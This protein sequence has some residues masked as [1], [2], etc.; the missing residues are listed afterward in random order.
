MTPDG[1]SLFYDSDRN[2]NADIWRTTVGVNQPDAITHDPADEFGPALS[3]DGKWLAYYSYRAG[4]THGIVI[5]KPMDGGPIVEV[6]DDSTV[7]IWPAWSADGRA[8]FWQCSN[9]QTRLCGGAAERDNAGHWHAMASP[10]GAPI[11]QSP[12]WPVWS[13][14]RLEMAWCC[15]P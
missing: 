13:T 5:V 10:A 1:K 8:L 12:G 6:N 2:G 11:P 15:R 14:D 4:T 3:P 7:G 9:A